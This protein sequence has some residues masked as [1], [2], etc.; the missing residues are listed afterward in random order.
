[1][2]GGRAWRRAPGLDTHE[3][4]ELSPCTVMRASQQTDA[5]GQPLL[6]SLHQKDCCR[7]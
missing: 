3:A 7:R 6:S 2:P 1:M 4:S 5:L